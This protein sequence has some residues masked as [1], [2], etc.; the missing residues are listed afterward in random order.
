MHALG[1]K[2]EQSRADRDKYV[3]IIWS[4]IKKGKQ[5]FNFNMCKNCE[6]IGSYD[7]DSIMHSRWNE[8]AINPFKS[9]VTLKV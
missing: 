6:V 9:T 4:N 5:N 3:N 7:Y 1:L 8:H 2:H